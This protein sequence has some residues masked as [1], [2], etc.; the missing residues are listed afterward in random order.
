MQF[1]LKP[2]L[3]K[4]NNLQTFDRFYTGQFN[5]LANSLISMTSRDLNFIPAFIFAAN[6]NTSLLDSINNFDSNI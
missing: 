5:S 3:P 1:P 2:H 6:F 4:I